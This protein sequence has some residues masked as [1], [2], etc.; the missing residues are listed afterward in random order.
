MLACRWYRAP[1]LLYGARSYGPAVDMWAVG[2]VFAEI[3][4][5]YGHI[6]RDH[7]VDVMEGPIFSL[8]CVNS[9]IYHGPSDWLIGFY[10]TPSVSGVSP[11]IFDDRDVRWLIS[12]SWPS[13]TQA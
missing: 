4:G 10:R 5:E 1:E 7:F 9:G 3:I 13:L 2:L 11:R 6:G 12:S 8:K